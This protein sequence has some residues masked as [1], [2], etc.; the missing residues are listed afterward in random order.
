MSYGSV[1][2]YRKRLLR[3]HRTGERSPLAVTCRVCSGKKRSCADC[4][5]V[6]DEE[7]AIAVDR[8]FPPSL[9]NL[10]FTR[11]ATLREM[12]R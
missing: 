5:Q 12:V 2:Q 1:R 11:A 8:M 3:L 9:Q 6:L 7:W 4:Y 10:G